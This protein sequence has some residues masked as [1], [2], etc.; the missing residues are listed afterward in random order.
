MN[1]PKSP[2]GEAPV[3]LPTA[4]LPPPHQTM[5]RVWRPAPVA[6]ARLV[7][8]RLRLI[9]R[10]MYARPP[11]FAGNSKRCSNARANCR[12]SARQALQID[13]VAELVQARA[14]GRS[15]RCKPLDQ[16][17]HEHAHDTGCRRWRVLAANAASLVV[18]G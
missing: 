2:P 18:H 4:N 3:A 16:N 6:P 14:A 15:G 10:H 8:C 17:M 5:Q 13:N 9:S 7:R 12:R 1:R 11:W